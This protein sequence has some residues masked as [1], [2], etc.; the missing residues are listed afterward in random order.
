MSDETEKTPFEAFQPFTPSPEPTPSKG[1]PPGRRK[2]T[3]VLNGK[4]AVAAAKA[5]AKKPRK[6]RATGKTRQPRAASLDVQTAVK[7]LVGLKEADSLLLYQMVTVLQG[8]PKKARQRIIA[9]L[10]KV[11]A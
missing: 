5:E 7:A 11:F 8:H 9:A 10:G 6:P 1:R 3:K 4:E 2:L